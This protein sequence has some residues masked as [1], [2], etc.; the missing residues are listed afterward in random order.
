MSLLDGVSRPLPSKSPRRPGTL[1][2]AA[3]L[4]LVIAGACETDQSDLL[5]PEPPVA[6]SEVDGSPRE[7][8]ISEYVEGSSNNKAIEIFNGTGAAV[9]LAAEGYQLLYYFNGN[10]SPGLT[11][12]LTGTVLD[13]D[14]YVVAQSSAV[15]EI[16]DEADQ[17]NGSGWFNG[18]DVVVLRNGSE[19][20]DAFGQIGTDPGSAW[21]SGSTSAQDNT[22]RRQP[23]VCTGDSNPNDAFD[24]AL[25]WGAFGNNVVDGLG[26]HSVSC[27]AEAGPAVVALTPADG[28]FDVPVDADLSVTFSEPVDVA[29][30]AF[31]LT[32]SISGPRVL[33]Q[34]G[35]DVTF[36]F[37][38]EGD[39]TAG[40]SCLIEIEGEGVSD[41]DADD[42]PDALGSDV[43]ATFTVAGANVCGAPSTPIY[44]VQGDGP[45]T[46]WSDVRLT[47]E[48]IVVGDY[49]GPSPNLRGFYVQQAEGD[50]EGA[51][52]DGLFVFNFSDDDVSLGDRVRVTGVAQ[53][54]QDQTQL[55]S[56]VD[57]QAC[58][59]GTVEPTDISFPVSSLDDLEAVEGMLVRVPQ[60]L[61]VTEHFQLA[62]FGQVLMSGSNRLFQPTSV[63]APGAPALAVAEA[64]LLNQIFVDDELNE[65]NPEPIR[66]G[67][68][69]NPLGAS[70][71]LR[72]GDQATG[73]VGVMSYTWAGN[74]ASGNA[75]RL[76]PV[77]ALG[78]GVPGFAPANPRPAFS[79]DV[80]GGLKVASFNVLNYFNTFDGCSGG[81]G[82]PPEGCRG[83]DD[84]FEL[85]RQSAK[86][87][88]AINQSDFD[89]VGLI[90][91]E[92]DGYGPES[93]LAELVDRLNADA[94]SGSWDFID[95]DAGTGRAN[96]A[97]T[98]AIR[99]AFIYKPTSVTPVGKTA[100]LDTDEFV[101]GGDAEIRNR[102]AIAQAFQGPDGGRFIAVINHFK[103]K[104]SP[105]AVPDA[106]DGQGNCN[107][108]RTRAAEALADWLAADPTG[109][110]D[111]DIAVLGDLNAYAQE[112]PI[113]VLEDA[114][115]EDLLDTFQGPESYSFVFS[116]QWG[117]LDYALS[118]SSLSGQTTGAAAWHINAD[119]PNALD[120]NTNF[121]SS[122][123]I[124]SLFAPDAFRS[125]DHD[126]VVMGLEL[127]EPFGFGGFGRPV[128]DFPAENRARAGRAIPLKWTFERSG[129][130]DPFQ[131]GYPLSFPV[132]CGT[133]VP[134]GAGQPL[135]AAGG[136]GL[137]VT[138]G[139]RRY[140][141]VWKTDRAWTGQCRILE[142]RFVDG[143]AERLLVRFR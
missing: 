84:A 82:G 10:S 12:S 21:G 42:P 68:E 44:T 27:G 92:N 111:P 91:I 7:L 55:G 8:F 89:V 114:G 78:G 104:G 99:V 86:I 142:A 23:P 143:T 26:S 108:V 57:I 90:E 20:I 75:Y 17:M 66:F 30:G 5:A 32:C 54:F 71:T 33:M 13:G 36:G 64:N 38:V 103:S 77:G 62:R 98:D 53:E 118:T 73:I 31:A 18:D 128:E 43:R 87:V 93:S 3:L 11:I 34:S 72:G 141:F 69:G 136:S 63:A 115:Y 100:A 37:A 60:T 2:S 83:A 39:L 120:Y 49:E 130:T 35:G 9:D 58:G 28:S 131:P 110:G 51:T 67:R 113:R 41:V 122:D 14:V 139:G 105:C 76:R 15:P 85:E 102:P 132:T 46:P 29:P 101:N 95:V 50:G 40:E 133:T 48:G 81:V 16:L 65:Q 59:S 125:S 109:T 96:A 74:R 117:Y 25:E 140:R 112:D 138:R 70:N 19:V 119:E 126:P 45:A 80:G 124:V 107:V 56:G 24:P 94:G 127:A 88:S 123:Q 121:K 97:G 1:G 52:S 6:A 129:G 116:G 47:V 135:Q 22:L 61:Y 79:P 4:L 137:K 106:G 134:V